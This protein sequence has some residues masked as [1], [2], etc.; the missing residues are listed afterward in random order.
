M[1]DQI[2]IMTL[3]LCMNATFGFYIYIRFSPRKMILIAMPESE[4]ERYKESIPPLSKLNPYGWKL[5]IGMGSTI[6]GCLL[7]LIK[8]FLIH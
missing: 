7:L 1:A 8:L 6:A 3:L 4:Y 5:A 2:M